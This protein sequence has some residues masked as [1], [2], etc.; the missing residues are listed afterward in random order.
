LLKLN[1]LIAILIIATNETLLAVEA[2]LNSSVL[3]LSLLPVALH[4]LYQI[5]LRLTAPPLYES[6]S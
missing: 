2:P 5:I 6:E 4:Y 3:T 1:A